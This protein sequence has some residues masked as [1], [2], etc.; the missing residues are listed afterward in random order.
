[1]QCQKRTDTSFACPLVG[2][3]DLERRQAAHREK[4][5]RMTSTIDTRAPMAQPHLTLY[6]RDYVAKKRATTEAAFSDLKMIQS[7]AKTMTRQ[8]SIPER[9]GPV[10]L[11]ADARKSEIFRIMKENHRL[12][13]RLETLEPV[14]S[15]ENLLREHK[16]RHRYTILTSHS[17][18]LAGEYHADETRIRAEDKQKNDA[19]VR[20]VELRRTKYQ[21]MQSSSGSMSMPSLTPLASTD[22]G[23]LGAHASP[24]PTPKRAVKR[25]QAKPQASPGGGS[26]SS[27]HRPAPSPLGAK[28][29]KVVLP[30]SGSA[31]GEVG[32]RVSFSGEQTEES[33]HDWQRVGGPTPH[34][35]KIPKEMFFEDED[36]DGQQGAKAVPSESTPGGAAVASLAQASLAGI[37]P[38][39][40][41]ESQQAAAAEPSSTPSSAVNKLAQ[42]SVAGQVPAAMEEKQE[43]ALPAE[44]SPASPA[45]AA[46]AA[47]SEEVAPAA[48]SETP[49]QAAP[50]QEF[51]PGQAQPEKV[52][53]VAGPSTNVDDSVTKGKADASASGD[54]DDGFE[55]YEDDF[56]DE[57]ANNLSKAMPDE[58]GMSAEN[59]GTFEDESGTFESSKD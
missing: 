34:P 32:R 37:V 52:V 47:A 21:M 20:S 51:D 7:I 55:D 14:V 29:T 31:D 44:P 19:M 41:E 9:K 15:T 53:G 38:Q 48:A 18:R 40:L 11:S 13:D 4:V 23:V 6:G 10:S 26:S 35:K 5:Q 3:R 8:P 36:E 24:K 42:A 12:L 28:D 17:K 25:V 30:D 54:Y 39:K 27:S 56:A 57:T 1:M 22:P 43:A 45:Q 49:A 59:S 58:Q 46:P 2:R 50:A 16:A 33:A